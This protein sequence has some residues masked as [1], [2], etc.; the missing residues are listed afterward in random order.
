MNDGTSP[1]QTTAHAAW[2]PAGE[3]RPAVSEDA[4]IAAVANVYDPEIP[5]NVYELGLIYVIDI[6]AAGDVKVEM[7]LTAPACPS[8]Q[9]LPEMVREEI[10][11]VPGVTSVAVE[12]VWDPPWDPSRMS[13]EARL[14]LN[15]F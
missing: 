5:V 12:T 15:M 1:A 7:T 11:A 9:E 8:A 14:A 4:I 3:T 2:T 13:E 6:G 10:L